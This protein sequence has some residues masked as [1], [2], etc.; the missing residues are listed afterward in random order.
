MSKFYNYMVCSE[1]DGFFSRNKDGKYSS[2]AIQ[3]CGFPD[4]SEEGDNSEMNED[5]NDSGEDSTN[6]DNDDKEDEDDEDDDLSNSSY[7]V[8]EDEDTKNSNGE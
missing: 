6:D 7:I 1:I 4:D 5:N 8:H 2:Y 3:Q